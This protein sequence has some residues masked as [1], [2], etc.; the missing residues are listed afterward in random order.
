MKSDVLKDNETFR[1]DGEYFKKDNLAKL[2]QIE[3]LGYH[4][5]GENAFVTDGI[6]ESITFDEDSNILLLSAKA[7]KE[8]IFD[9]S[10]LEKIAQQQHDKNPRTALQVD[11]II[12][13]TVGTI[14]NVAVVTPDILP[15]N[16]DRHVG[17]IR[18][19]NPKI[20]PYFVS[21][22]LLSKYG[23]FQTWREATGNV[24]LNL[25]IYKIKTLKLPNLTFAFQQTIE[26]TVKKAH[27]QSSQAQELYQQAERV[28]LEE[29]GLVGFKP[30]TQ[31]VS[32]KTFAQS[33]GTTGRLDAEYYQPK[34]EALEK[35]LNTFPTTTLSQL[36][37]Y[38]IA[39]GITPK[40]GGDDYT[41]S[42]EGIPFVRAVDLVD[43]IVSLDKVNYVKPH[44]HKQ[45][46]KRTQ[47]KCNDVLF[48]IAGTVGRT[49]LYNQ[50]V[51]AN[52][53]QAVAILRFDE[54]VVQHFYLI[55]FFNS[56]IGKLL[57]EKF[58]RQGL[59]TNLNLEE[60][61]NLYL[62]VLEKPIQ[63]KISQLVRQG[64]ALKTQSE[65]LLEIAKRGVE[66]AIET[67][68]AQAQSWM[69]SQLEAQTP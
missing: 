47:L 58:S 38:P 13:S 23:R 46:L 1:I 11:D 12:I 16:S 69:Q 36:V 59:Q 44:I 5:I 30:S 21:T 60:V 50:T 52:I 22:F 18:I 61:G 25:F 64:L 63:D 45:T 34:Y 31:G 65:A 15:A 6:H 32:I 40:A 4:Y 7:P 35:A 29:L 33:F 19:K 55:T 62:P 27:H 24:Q 10:K 14:G 41:D 3:A 67:T 20:S 51:E 43:G 9:L 17:I 2:R 28:L 26:S 57:V 68:E 48:S 66:L 39:S 49:A 56:F 54:S 42:S 8:N 37:N 53:N